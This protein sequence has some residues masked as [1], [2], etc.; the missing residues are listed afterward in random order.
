M[1]ED[2]STVDSDSKTR[3][4]PVRQIRMPTG[5]LRANTVYLFVI[6]LVAVGTVLRLTGSIFIPFVIAI[7]LSFVFSP[8][9]SF[10]VERKVPRFIAITVVLL[11]FLAFGFLI[12][13]VVYSSIQSLLREFPAY[14][15]R[16]L[17]L[18][19]DL[20]E[21][22]ELPPD[23]VSQLEV[24]RTIG[25]TLISVSG[26]FMSF[27]SGFMVVLVFLLFLLMEK[28][29]A[30]RKIAMALRDETTRRMSRVLI[31]ITSQIGRYV[32]VKLFVSALTAGIVYIAFS[33]IGV[34]FPFIWAVLTFLFN[35]IPS[36]GSIAITFI[37]GVFALVQF[38]P[39]WNLI[40]AAFLSMSITQFLIGNVLDPKLLGDRLNLSPVVI[41]LS[42]LLWGWL[43]GTAGLFLAVPLT[44][45]IKIVLESVPDLE[46]FGILMGTGNFKPRVSRRKRRE[47]TED[48]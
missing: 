27:A 1:S 26:N 13:F 36:I 12:A 9:V 39:E 47:R 35:F 25:N 16:F 33:V 43:W 41:L 34:D 7:L 14:Q 30:R 21:R 28:P 11:I 15:S 17:R 24:T 46:A 38:L 29:Y 40:L 2:S 8:V 37:S 44:V 10:L 48:E 19:S 31:S 23:L 6:A 5:F 32:A 3:T 20:V 22:F 18:F 45:A 4:R 42:L